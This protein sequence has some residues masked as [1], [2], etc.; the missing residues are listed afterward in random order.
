M[1]NP[2]RQTTNDVARQMAATPLSETQEI[3]TPDY[4][5]LIPFELVGFRTNSKPK[6]YVNDDGSTVRKVAFATIKIGGTNLKFSAGINLQSKTENTPQGAKQRRIVLV[7]MPSQRA[8]AFNSPVF[9][10]DDAA[11]ET[12][13]EMWRNDLKLEYVKWVKSHSTE[14][15]AAHTATTQVSEVELTD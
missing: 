8:G 1:A 3:A 12:A 10:S 6:D 13:L 4:A 11:T 9:S 7:T 14:A 15:K 2:N 5:K